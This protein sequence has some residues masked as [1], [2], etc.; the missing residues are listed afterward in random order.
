[1]TSRPVRIAYFTDVL[2]VWAYVA[3]IKIDELKRHF[4]DRIALNYHYLTLFGNTHDRLVEGWQDRG[5]IEAY[6]AHV[7]GIGRDFGHVEIHPDIWCRNRPCSSLSCHL[8]LKAVALLEERGEIPASPQS[9]WQGRTLHE[10]TVWRLRCAFFRD[11]QDIGQLSCQLDIAS[12]LDLPCDRIR[13]LL[14]NGAAHA[15]FTA[16]LEIREKYAVRGSPTLVLNEGRQI[17]YGNV[18][19]KIIEANIHE[20][21]QRPAGQATWC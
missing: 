15:A 3:Q 12:Q 21:L 11:L 10:E 6:G 18:G 16:D 5:G 19:Y 13:Q 4:Q 1:M 8:F 2:C 7:Q 9:H 17:L 20:L 14:E